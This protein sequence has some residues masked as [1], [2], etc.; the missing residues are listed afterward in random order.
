MLNEING[1]LLRKFM[2]TIKDAV[3]RVSEDIFHLYRD[4]KDRIIRDTCSA[5]EAIKSH[6]GRWLFELIQNSDDAGATNINIKIDDIAV[7]IGDNGSGLTGEAVESLCGTHLSNKTTGMIGRKGVGFKSVYYISDNPIILR[8]NEGGVEFNKEKAKRW[9]NDNGLNS[10]YVPYQW[11]PFYISYDEA[12]QKYKTLEEFKEYTTIVILPYKQNNRDNILKT[13]NEFPSYTLFPLRNIIFFE[14]PDYTVTIKRNED[15]WEL[16]NSKN[17]ELCTFKV[18]YCKEQIPEDIL[19]TLETGRDKD[20]IPK[21]GVS[22]LVAAPINDTIVQPLNNYYPLLV[23]YPTE[24]ISPIR[25]LLHAEFIVNGER[26]KII[27]IENNAYNNWIASRLSFYIKRFVEE[28]FSNKLPCAN[29]KL[30]KPLL[31]VSTHSIANTLWKNIISICNDI[32]ISNIKGEAVLDISKAFYIAVPK[33]KD[34]ARKIIQATEC[35]NSLI[36]ESFDNDSESIEVLKELGV[37]GFGEKD[38]FEIMKKYYFNYENDQD[39]IWACWE[40]IFQFLDSCPSADIDNFLQ[41]FK[42]IPL[43][44]VNKKLYSCNQLNEKIIT[45]KDENNSNNIPDWLPLIFI[46][47]WFKH[48]IIEQQGNN[49]NL[50]DIFKQFNIKK[51]DKN[52]ILDAIK[53]AIEQFWKAP[54]AN[55]ERFLKYI[56]SLINDDKQNVLNDNKLKELSVCP[57]PCKRNG[58]EEILWEKANTVYFGKEWKNEDLEYLFSGNE[59]IYWLISKNDMLNIFNII[60]PN[61]DDSDVTFIFQSMG[62][63]YCPRII[64]ING[65]SIDS[66]YK[67]I[68]EKWK[69]SSTENNNRNIYDI[70]NIYLLDNIN[71][72]ELNNEHLNIL[73]RILFKYWDYYREYTKTKFE[74]KTS[75]ERRLFTWHYDSLW[76]YEL[77]NYEYKAIYNHF[78]CSL[79]EAWCPNDHTNKIL[80]ALLVCIDLDSLIS[81]KN[82]DDERNNIRQWLCSTIQLKQDINDIDCKEWFDIINNRIPKIMKFDNGTDNE[83]K[84]KDVIRI[85]DEFLGTIKEKEYIY[86]FYDRSFFIAKLLCK[87]GNNYEYISDRKI[88]YIADN[89][90]YEELFKND[91][92]LFHCSNNYIYLASKIFYINK[93]SDNIKEIIINEQDLLNNKKD[94]T[95]IINNTLPYVY[96][97]RCFYNKEIRE[98]R[99]KYKKELKSIRIYTVNKIEASYELN[100][101]KKTINDKKYYI[102]DKSIFIC[103]K[104]AN[105][106]SLISEALA[107]CLDIPSEIDF[108]EN[109]MRCKSEEEKKYKLRQRGLS[110]TDINYVDE[111]IDKNINEPMPINIHEPMPITKKDT[112]VIQ[113]ETQSGNGNG[114]D[115]DSTTEIIE[116]GNGGDHPKSDTTPPKCSEGDEEKPKSDEEE[117]KVEN[118]E[119][120]N[121]KLKDIENYDITKC[122]INVKKT[123]SG[124]GGSTSKNNYYNDNQQEHNDNKIP[125]Q[126]KNQIEDKSKKVIKKILENKGYK[127]EIMP[128]LNPGYDIIAKKENE[129]DIHIEVKGHLTTS[130]VIEITANELFEYISS[131]KDGNFKWQL[132]DVRNLK[133]DENKEI[134]IMI[135][136]EIKYEALDIKTLKLHLNK[137]TPISSQI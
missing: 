51:P 137:L 117:K 126:L 52:T 13:I 80:G 24:E 22:F 20:M 93:L 50:I 34:L 56:L 72:S 75:R 61:Y 54:D 133:E 111:Y 79:K 5:E 134:E 36:H 7:Y 60:F 43:I 64:E 104:D 113:Q 83:K 105:N 94:I 97:L 91:I 100:G 68:Y 63:S 101:I 130:S 92:F 40:W 89:Y 8:A 12:V 29:I 25:L 46:D 118:E 42:D 77:K 57:V 19:S 128:H 31:N 132:W 120:K 82:N 90:E 129:K 103:D 17:N 112:I 4:Y 73:L 26:T 136:D 116:K 125:E 33:R 44:P 108:I 15:I 30:L 23:F 127:V 1:V 3:T 32:K 39:V 135:Y 6:I 48:K 9:M 74:G 10:D 28:S 99:E 110:E 47:D 67:N 114:Q 37:K 59:N 124:S 121:I 95:N 87:K 78:S 41:Q 66:Y 123:I 107:K 119:D 53:Y 84:Y 62:V 71:I 18:L 70:N 45:W 76:F 115:G 88:M 65:K 69:K 16:S 122:K 38:L 85:Y 96:A 58:S 109:I 49:K 55:P 102:K 21:D 11:I 98:N 131:K 106:N 27:S 35:S 14:A 2:S 81:D 86:H